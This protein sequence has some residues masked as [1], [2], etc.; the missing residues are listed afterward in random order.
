MAR[1]EQ[2]A[3]FVRDA[4][5]AGRSRAEIAQ[6]LGDAGWSG[7]EIADALAAWAD[8]PFVPPVPRPQATVS[9]RDFFVYA[10]TFGV[11][12]F[13][14]GHLVALLHAL[15]DRAFAQSYGGGAYTIRW[16]MAVLI[17]TVPLYLWLTMRERTKLARDPALYRSA[18]R[19]WLTYI[20]LL[21]AA[22]VLLGD[23]VST[24]YA[25]LSGDLTLQFMLKAGV[26][27][28]V[29][30]GIFAFYLGDIRRGDAA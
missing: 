18:M 11:L 20:T 26:I 22:A 2:L 17:V 9:A 7:T 28:L 16:G 29:A 4:L 10:L 6:V 25:L 15:I 23:L 24:I 27:A 14:A 21:I 30:G 13:A 1:N 12:L 8:V 3:G 19:K 5:S